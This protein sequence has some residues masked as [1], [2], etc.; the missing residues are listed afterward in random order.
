MTRPLRDPGP[1]PA[2]RRPAFGPPQHLRRLGDERAF[3]RLV[4]LALALGVAASVRHDLVAPP[5][6][7]RRQGGAMIVDRAVDE[8]RARQ[9]QLVEKIE[10]A[11]RADAVAVLAPRPVQHVGLPVLGA[12]ARHPAPREGEMLEVDGEVAGQ[13]RPAR[14]GELRSVA[15]RRIGKTAVIG[16][17]GHAP[18]CPAPPGSMRDSSD[19]RSIAWCFSTPAMC[20][21]NRA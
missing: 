9:T 10:Q 8:R 1:E 16:Q 17:R 11:P 3:G 6:E 13:A 7:R 19:S 21:A 4:A 20:S 15:D 5:A 12:R 14:P 2:A 18:S